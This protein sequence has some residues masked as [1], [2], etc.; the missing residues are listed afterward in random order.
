[1]YFAPQSFNK[2]TDLRAKEARVESSAL[3]PI[4]T[5]LVPAVH[6]KHAVDPTGCGDVWGAT[7]FSRLLAGD[8]LDHAIRAA[9]RAAARNVEHRGA[10]GLADHLRGKLSIT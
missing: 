3:D 8:S 7:H 9:H 6:A 5:Q 2:L 1:M 10:G 4:R